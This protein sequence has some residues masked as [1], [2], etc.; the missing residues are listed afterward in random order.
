MVKRVLSQFAI[1]HAHAGSTSQGEQGF[2]LLETRHVLNLCIARGTLRALRGGVRERVKAAGLLQGVKPTHPDSMAISD[3]DV[4]KAF[5]RNNLKVSDGAVASRIAALAEEFGYTATEL[6]DKYDFYATNRC[7][8]VFAPLCMRKSASTSRRTDAR[9]HERTHCMCTATENQYRCRRG[10]VISNEVTAKL[11]AEFSQ[12]L[13]KRQPS[14]AVKAARPSR[15]SMDG[16][17]ALLVFPAAG[18]M[19][20]L[21]CCT[22]VV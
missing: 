9:G 21:Q 20:T 17:V 14:T 7:G 6:S 10:S 12:Q 11:L 15:M 3:M 4:R 8:A 16:C 13:D 1:A 5:K 2:S 19:C 22:R 18:T